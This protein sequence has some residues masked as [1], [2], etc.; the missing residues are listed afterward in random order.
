MLVA[1]GNNA[2]KVEPVSFI[3]SNLGFLRKLTAKVDAGVESNTK[4]YLKYKK[5]LFCCHGN[6]T[7]HFSVKKLRPMALI[8]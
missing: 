8:T 6:E 5:I 3:N 4:N 2:F 1:L 7:I